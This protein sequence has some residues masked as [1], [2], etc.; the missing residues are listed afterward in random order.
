VHG[1]PRL[2]IATSDPGHDTAFAE[3]AARVLDAVIDVPPF[4]VAAGEPGRAPR[5]DV[6]ARLAAAALVLGDARIAAGTLRAFAAAA[7]VHGGLP[8]SFAHASAGD[9]AP[10][11]AVL[12][13][14]LAARYVAA[15]GERGLP[16]EIWP[17]LRDA[18][19]GEAVD[20]VAEAIGARTATA[21]TDRV[22][23][24]G[25]SRA[26]P[27]APAR[28]DGA[29]NAVR[30][31]RIAGPAVAAADVVL[32]T[33]EDTLGFRPDAARQRV[34][35]APRP[36]SAWKHADADALVVADA[37][38]RFSYRRTDSGMALLLD[39]LSGAVPLRLVL[40]A[41]LPLTVV[42]EVRVNGVPADV[43]V[44]RTTGRATIPLQLSLDGEKLI[45]VRGR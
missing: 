35:L 9:D 17:L 19:A 32:Q 27:S 29:R 5:I 26:A 28:D 1:S 38:V 11:R 21:M 20:A 3:A 22:V 13:A 30:S 15:T 8:A 31:L 41:A 6:A 12:F 33:V 10:H 4:G 43:A 24:L 23:L 34:V 44:Q 16:L 36:P 39:Q 25:R 2:R 45:D 42:H 14:C 7:R 40:Y 37:E 18:P